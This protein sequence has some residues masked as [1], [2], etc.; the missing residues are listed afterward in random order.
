[1]LNGKVAVMQQV[2]K[3]SAMGQSPLHHVELAALADKGPQQGGVVFQE[4]ALLGHLTL[5]L[6]SD[7]AEQ[8]A[9]V[10][11]ILGLS[12]PLTPLSS[13]VLAEVSINW[14][15]PDEWLILLPGE[16]TYDVECRFR[17]L[18]MGHYSLINS[19][20][21]ST[22]LRLSGDNVVDVL[23]K[24]TGI[25]FYDSRFPV[26]KVVSTV[27][28]KSTAVIRRCDEQCYELV[29]R[30]S[31]ADYLWLWIQDASREFGLVVKS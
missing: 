2:P 5:R 31:F 7:H 9:V 3:D 13:A 1:M 24:S 11:D 29:I 30:R 25:D 16:Q 6:N 20:G 14:I 8:M 28:A 23:K 21:G 22:V 18:M 17:E 26:G 15:A 4:R 12:L 10:K 27:F 19:S